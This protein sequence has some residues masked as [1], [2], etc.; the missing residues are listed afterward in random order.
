MTM[1]SKLENMLYMITILSISQ[2]LLF[3]QLQYSDLK[4]MLN[5]VTPFEDEVS[6]EYLNVVD[7]DDRVSSVFWFD[8]DSIRFTKLFHYDNKEN[9]YLISEFREKSII[10]EIYF[11][12]SNIPDR[13]IQF[14]FGDNFHSNEDYI[15]EI[16]YNES[17]LPISYN[18]E[19][20]RNDYIGHII[21]NYDEHNY[22]IREAWFHGKRKIREFLK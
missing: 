2:S 11:T 14:M 20:S 17:K 22:I 19:S 18:I 21:L 15:T 5:E 13:F 16:V 1:I 7:N 12:S 8:Q 10:K 6:L 9:L 3:S 4:S